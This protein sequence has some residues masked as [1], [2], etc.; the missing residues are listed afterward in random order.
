M[1]K[2]KNY[3]CSGTIT[4]KVPFTT[5]VMSDKKSSV[6]EEATRRAEIILRPKLASLEAEAVDYAFTVK[7]NKGS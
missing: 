2:M 3:K 6:I 7:E 4:I 1:A 5:F